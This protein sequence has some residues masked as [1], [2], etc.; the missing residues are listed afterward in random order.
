MAPLEASCATPVGVHARVDGESLALDAFVG[1]PDGSEWLRDAIEA[2]AGEPL[3][4]GTELAERLLAAGAARAARPGRARGR[5][6]MAIA[7]DRR[8]P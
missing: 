5:R 8:G 1:L 2:D 3:A 6:S 4:A 7:I